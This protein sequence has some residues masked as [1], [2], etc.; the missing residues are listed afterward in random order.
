MSAG[1]IDIDRTQAAGVPDSGNAELAASISSPWL[2]A[3]AP[4][5]LARCF[6]DLEIEGSEEEIRAAVTAVAAAVAANDVSSLGSHDALLCH[7]TVELFRSELV[8]RWNETGQIPAHALALLQGF[9]MVSRALRKGGRVQPR[10]GLPGG[11]AFVA[12]VA[13]DLR[14]PL[15]SILFLA[16]TLLTERSGAVNETQKRQLG[17]I[18]SAALGLVSVASDIIELV[19]GGDG[20]TE[21]RPTLFSVT[22]MLESVHDIVR[23]MAEEKGLRVQLFPPSVDLRLGYPLALSRVLLN[24]TTNGLKFTESGFVE[25]AVR[26]IG[27]SRVEF[28]VRDTG[29]GF[30]PAAVDDLYQPFRRTTD[31]RK[32]GFSGAGL[33][34]A[35]SRKL[36][37]AMGS[38]L[39]F[40]TRETWGTRFFFELN[41]PPGPR[42]PID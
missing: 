12:G 21:R 3:V 25:I 32:Y 2:R 37:S 20:L 6:S 23:P 28:S 19:R 36:V 1:D 15:T 31:G 38:T 10:D 35:I 41:L 11:A 26:G 16:E 30:S 14:S 24:L 40:E 29:R 39:Q 22:E 42:D 17:I 34:L 27:E 4:A 8:T 13:H 18:Y 5:V 9:E 33:G 7:R